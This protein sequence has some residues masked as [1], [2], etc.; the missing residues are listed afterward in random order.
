MQSTGSGRERPEP[1]SVC[2]GRGGTEPELEKSSPEWDRPEEGGQSEQE[3][4][5]T[6]KVCSQPEG[7]SRRPKL[8]ASSQVPET[9]SSGHQRFE[10]AWK[11]LQCQ[12][13]GRC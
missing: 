10:D 4:V 2:E 11:A 1:V 12:E 6:R 9:G 7:P 13:K 8:R 3:V 5:V